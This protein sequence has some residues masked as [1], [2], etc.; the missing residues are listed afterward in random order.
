MTGATFGSSTMPW[1]D[2]AGGQTTRRP[3]QCIVAGVNFLLHAALNA[4]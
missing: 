1:A 2:A 4:Q 3:A